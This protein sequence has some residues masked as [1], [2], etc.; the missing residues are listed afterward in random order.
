[1]EALLKKK[2][3]KLVL[4]LEL[5]KEEVLE[6]L[7]FAIGKAIFLAIEDKII[8]S[9]NA[10]HERD[11]LQAKYEGDYET[12]ISTFVFNHLNSGAEL[13]HS[14]VSHLISKFVLDKPIEKNVLI[15]DKLDKFLIKEEPPVKRKNE[16]ESSSDHSSER[17]DEKQSI[18]SFKEQLLSKA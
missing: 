14:A 12:Q 9:V 3:L 1:M 4:L 16:S 18:E 13:S 2:T 17:I 7:P 6:V 10:L 8:E 15:I 5:P 11:D